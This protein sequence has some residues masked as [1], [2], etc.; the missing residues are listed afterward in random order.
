MNSINMA[1]HHWWSLFSSRNR[2]CLEWTGCAIP[3]WM[4]IKNPCSQ[5]E[6]GRRPPLFIYHI[7]GY[8]CGFRYVWN[9]FV[10]ISKSHT[11]IF[12]STFGTLTVSLHLG[13]SLHRGRIFFTHPPEWHTHT[14]DYRDT[15]QH[16]YTKWILMRNDQSERKRNLFD[17]LSSPP[18]WVAF[19]NGPI[20]TVVMPM[21]ICDIVIR[22]STSIY[23]RWYSI[24][25]TDIIYRSAFTMGIH[26]I[27]E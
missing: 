19:L 27:D 17:E 7:F 10:W 21:G 5:F 15:L 1:S 9:C 22:T 20:H 24:T 23:I 8:G 13:G 2:F 18:N 16:L 14:G 3:W 26:Q 6:D 25:N 11:V 12:H 4:L